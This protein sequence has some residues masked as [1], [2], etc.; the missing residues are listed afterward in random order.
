MA[1]LF[2]SFSYRSPEFGRRFRFSHAL[3]LLL[4]AL[5]CAVASAQNTT[6]SGTVFDPRTTN[7]L[8]LP[9]VLV[10]ATTGAVAP[11]PSG[12]QCLTVQTPTDPG[13]A[14]FTYTDFQGNFTL[15]GIPENATYTLVIQAGKWRSQFPN[16]T[17]AAT[18]ISG[19]QLHMPADHT[20][21]DIPMIAVVTGEADGAECV[22]RDMGV[23]DSEFTDDTQTTNPGRIH[24]YQ[25]GG[26]P[27]AYISASTPKETA[28]TQNAT[29]L[30]QY[31]MVM[32]PC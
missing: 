19:L 16:T 3:F 7:A 9:N 6:I 5:P 27:G 17:V 12:V 1:T 11:L 32:F 25:G 26:S 23:A 13:V 24:L 30:A 4:I 8:P 14:A 18:P 21:G 28:L 20:Q 2:R 22:L 10:Y 29:L 15:T 31:D